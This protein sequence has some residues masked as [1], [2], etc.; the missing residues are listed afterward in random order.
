MNDFTTTV[1]ELIDMRSFSNLW[2]WIALAVMWSTA[3]HYVLG[4]P[5]DMVARAR[6]HGG[7]TM[8]DLEAL[9]RINVNRLLYIGN[10][11]GVWLIALF[12][13]VLSGF[14]TA[15]FLYEIEF[16]QATFFLL[17]PLALIWL[18][19]LN[20]AT[21]IHEKDLMGEALCRKFTR[22][23]FIIQVLGVVF[24]FITSI[25][26]MYQNYAIGVLGGR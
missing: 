26:G 13:A 9:S 18:L 7:Q 25:W 6:K 8:V 3:S 19:T 2:Y 23:R 10:V 24:I 21:I 4:I 5:F 17:F 20:S 22:H 11:A 16:A 15:G 12:S 1:F 14:F